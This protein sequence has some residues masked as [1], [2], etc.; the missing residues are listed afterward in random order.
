MAMQDVVYGGFQAD[1]SSVEY[2]K[3]SCGIKKN[4]EESEIQILHLQ[5]IEYPI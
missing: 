5:E 2:L 3:Y 4:K 1:C